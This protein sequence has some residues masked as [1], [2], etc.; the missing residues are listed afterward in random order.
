MRY[1]AIAILSGALGFAL[2]AYWYSDARYFRKWE[3][4]QKSTD[5][6]ILWLEFEVNNLRAQ[7]TDHGYGETIDGKFTWK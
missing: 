1:L 7:A 6:Q 4:L 5:Q 2:G 3:A